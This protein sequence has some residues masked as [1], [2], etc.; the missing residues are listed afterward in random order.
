MN[1]L[2][3][4][5]RSC[6]AVFR[7]RRVRALYRLL[8]IGTSTTVLDVGGTF[9]FWQLAKG[10]GLPEPRV[11]ILNVRFPES[12]RPN[13]AQWVVGDGRRLPFGD[14]AFDFAISNSVI[15]HL[16]D[17]QSQAHFAAEVSRVAKRHFVQT[18]DSRFPIEP[19]YLAPFLHWLPKSVQHGLV[20]RVTPRG[21]LTPK[22]EDCAR[23]VN[24]LHL[25]NVHQMRALFPGSLILRERFCGL[26]KS[27]IAVG[28]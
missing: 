6:F 24:E 13:G 3:S 16:G 12:L 23:L 5:Y 22:G 19:H 20:P 8:G 14:N 1:L 7:P 21:F 25:L 26:P 4:I 10:L 17:S 2:D 27:I 11:T 15:E 9:H 18:P 28:G